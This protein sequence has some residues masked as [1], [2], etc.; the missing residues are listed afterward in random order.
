MNLDELISNYLDGELLE[1]EDRMLRS[2]LSSNPLAKEEFDEAVF[3][4]SALREDAVS[5]EPS[6]EF[7]LETEEKILMKILSTYPVSTDTV[8]IKPKSYRKYF[9]AAMVA[10]MLFGI[11]RISDNLTLTGNHD[12]INSTFSSYVSG[13]DEEMMTHTYIV[14]KEEGVGR[15]VNHRV[16]QAKQERRM[17]AASLSPKGQ[18]AVNAGNETDLVADNSA[19]TSND[20]MKDNS[21]NGGVNSLQVPANINPAHGTDAITIIEPGEVTAGNGFD[22]MNL[23]GQQSM[24]LKQAIGNYP[25]NNIPTLGNSPIFMNS[26]LKYDP[27]VT[28]SSFLG[29][30]LLKDGQDEKGKTV[31]NHISQSF[32]YS[33]TDNDRIGF[34]FGYTEYQIS[35]TVG[36]ESAV[37]SVKT[38]KVKSSRI[39]ANTE[40][41]NSTLGCSSYIKEPFVSDYSK[42]LYWGAAFYERSIVRTNGLDLNFRLGLGSSSDGALGF[43][44][45]YARYNLFT[46]LYLTCGSEGRLFMSK[47]SRSEKTN[48]LQKSLS[49]IY[50]LQFVF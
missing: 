13:L 46:G 11:F 30:E 27:N 23:Y 9:A 18:A 47:F 21:E 5:I 39:Q 16:R 40:G 45:I 43:G 2:E 36:T 48:E 3:I 31:I 22:K 12:A 7:I 14:P 28:L 37:S 26:I 17:I 29:T 4:S 33:I 25:V 24:N 8:Y 1:E 20:A 38:A 41:F 44:K 50:G 34:E 35:E 32:G 42:Q 15:N 19:G 6:G 49:I 10:V